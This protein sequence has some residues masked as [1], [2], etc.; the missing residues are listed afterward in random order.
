MAVAR[1]LVQRPKILLADEPVASLDPESSHQI[2]TLINQIA[3]E[4]QLTVLCTLR[5]INLAMEWGDRIIGL[6]QGKIM[7]DA[8]TAT[9]ST[10]EAMRI[11]NSVSAVGPS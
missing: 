11:Y 2:M 8:A 9:L 1:A 5:Q 10:A 3:T 4:D 6:R 7:L